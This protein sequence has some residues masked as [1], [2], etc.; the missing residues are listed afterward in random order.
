M[1]IFKKFL[2]RFGQKTATFFLKDY[3][4]CL[5]YARKFLVFFQP[6]CWDATKG[7]MSMKMIEFSSL[8]TR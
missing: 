7:Q 5:H 4:S 2:N 8:A 3:D 6:K 1:K